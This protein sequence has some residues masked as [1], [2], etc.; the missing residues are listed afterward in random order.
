MVMKSVKIFLVLLVTNQMAC[1]PQSSTNQ[2]VH[3][4]TQ[5]SNSPTIRATAQEPD[6]SVDQFLQKVFLIQEKRR[7]GLLKAWKEIPKHDHYRKARSS[8]FKNPNWTEK[9]YDRSYDYGEIAGAYG[10]AMFVIN[11]TIAEPQ[12]F[13]L[14]ILIERPANRY[15]AYWIY[16]DKD[17]SRVTLNRHS[18]NIYLAGLG[19]AGESLNCDIK[20]DKSERRWA[21]KGP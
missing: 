19:D 6:I 2:P 8:D 17:L 3:Q 1:S 5:P 10:L 16:R 14:I 7:A 18:G 9:E 11:K 20:W 21:C 13:G 4:S 15:D 12:S